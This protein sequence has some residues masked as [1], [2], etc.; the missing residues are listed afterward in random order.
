LAA[1]AAALAV[2]VTSA[3]IALADENAGGNGSGAGGTS[4]AGAPPPDEAGRFVPD[5]V[6]IMPGRVQI[7]TRRSARRGARTL[8][9]F[10]SAVENHGTGPLIVRAAR[11]SPTSPA[12]PAWQVVN[13]SDGRR[14]RVGD[15]GELRFVRGGGHSHWHLMGFQR[16]ELRTVSGATLRRDRKTGFCLGDRYSFNGR[17]R[18]PGEPARAV[19][20]ARCGLDSPSRT[21]LTQGISIG[22]GDEYPAR[23]E[24]QF[25]DI[26]GLPTGR[27]V[28]V[29]RH[30]PEGRMLELHKHNDVA[31]MLVKIVR[32]T[33]TR[34]RILSWCNFT[35]S[36]PS[37]GMHRR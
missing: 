13:R 29:Q 3:S 35:E 20:R 15:V 12:M 21:S 19:Y 8:L 11:P 30:D 26:T 36:C 37:P 7:D 34:A 31:S 22:F 9:S 33:R 24:G 16:F 27:Y 23:V 5:L 17:A 4:G 6:Q 28:L 2:V 25:I 18:M 1:I 14:E 32:G 10:A